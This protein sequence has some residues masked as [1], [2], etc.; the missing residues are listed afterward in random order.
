VDQG[1]PPRANFVWAS[2]ST[3]SGMTYSVPVFWT[4]DW[5]GTQYD[6]PFGFVAQATNGDAILALRGT[7]TDADAVQDAEIRQTPYELAAGYGSVHRGFDTIYRALSPQILPLL[8]GLS[9]VSRVLFAGHSLGGGLSTLAVPDV[10]TN[11]SLQPRPSLPML[12][13]NLASPRVGDPKFA[14]MMNGNLVPTFRIVN[15]EDIVPDAPPSV[16]GGLVY[17]HVGVPVDF[18]AQYGSVGDNH[19]LLIAYTYALDNPGAPEGEPPIRVLTVAGPLVR[20]P[21]GATLRLAF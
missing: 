8:N 9:G 15:T 1:C 18:T 10:I 2:P 13:Y 16:V 19:S 20:L 4:Y 3:P 17:K 14:D 21:R 11:T 5:F 12:H 7:V 6:E